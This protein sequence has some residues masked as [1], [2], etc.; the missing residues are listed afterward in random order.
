MGILLKSKFPDA[1][2]GP[3][4]QAGL[5]KD[6]RQVWCVWYIHSF[7]HKR[8]GRE[9]GCSGPQ[10]A[11]VIW[12]KAWILRTR[13]CGGTPHPEGEGALLLRLV[14][15][16]EP[17]RLVP[18]GLGKAGDLKPCRRWRSKAPLPPPAARLSLAPP[19]GRDEQG[20][21]G[22]AEAQLAE[23]QPQHHRA[24]KGGSRAGRQ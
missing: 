7:L 10:E 11:S 19:A 8:S 13:K 6:S 5:P 3:A 15:G 1:S 22:E 2:Q 18:G 9:P 12:R 14:P 16:R 17:L 4:L 23:S 20:A 21:S 24:K